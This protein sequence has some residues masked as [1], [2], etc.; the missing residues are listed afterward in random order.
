MKH[1][2]TPNSNRKLE[3]SLLVIMLLAGILGIVYLMNANASP[4]NQMTIKYD[5]AT[6]NQAFISIDNTAEVGLPTNISL[7]DLDPAET[8]LLVLGKEETI[9]VKQAEIQ[10]VFEQSG[11]HA[12]QLLEKGMS[13]YQVIDQF[14]IQVKADRTVAVY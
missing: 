8:Y 4:S 10:Y 11:K 12:V 13:G 2:T 6:P 7:R 1:E 14:E 3:S 9:E 5:Q